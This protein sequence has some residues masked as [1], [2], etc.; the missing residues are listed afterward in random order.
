MEE[1]KTSEI[2]IPFDINSL[3]CDCGC[4]QMKCTNELITALTIL[5]MRMQERITIVRGY[6]CPEHNNRFPGY[7]DSGHPKGWD[8]DILVVG[9][10]YRHKILKYVMDIFPVVTLTPRIFHLSVRPDWPQGICHIS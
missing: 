6:V 8:A 2:L 10:F 7:A 4:G 5:Q 9:Q 1:E 3:V